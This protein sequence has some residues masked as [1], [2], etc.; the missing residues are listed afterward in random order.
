MTTRNR[1]DTLRL[2][3]QRKVDLAGDGG[4]VTGRNDAGKAPESAMPRL[5]VATQVEVR[6]TT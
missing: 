1:D 5:S 2:D 4:G 3:C 6:P